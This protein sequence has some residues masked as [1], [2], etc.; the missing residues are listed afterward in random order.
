MCIPNAGKWVHPLGRAGHYAYLIVVKF[1]ESLTKT[2][3]IRDYI[4]GIGN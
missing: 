1:G 4:T 3:D 2:I